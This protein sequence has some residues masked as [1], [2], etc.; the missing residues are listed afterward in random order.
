MWLRLASSPLI[1]F[2]VNKIQ[3]YQAFYILAKSKIN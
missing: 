1:V 2:T 3:E